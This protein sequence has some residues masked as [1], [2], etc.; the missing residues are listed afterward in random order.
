MHGVREV[1]Y[2]RRFA[3]QLALHLQGAGLVVVDTPQGFALNEA[4]RKVSAAVADG[5]LCHGGDPILT[6]MAG[7]AQVRTGRNADA[8]GQRV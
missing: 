2:D 1:A 4:L 7:N 3:S 8:E 5:T 6:W